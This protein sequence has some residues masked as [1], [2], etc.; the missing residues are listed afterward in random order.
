[1]ASNVPNTDKAYSHELVTLIMLNPSNEH[2]CDEAENDRPPG[3]FQNH[4]HRS[5]VIYK[6]IRKTGQ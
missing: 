4:A 5:V 1:M 6:Q 2:V 3:L